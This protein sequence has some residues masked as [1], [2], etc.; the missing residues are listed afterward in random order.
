[1][2]RE[3]TLNSRA[4]G[5]G[6]SVMVVTPREAPRAVIQLSHGVCGC[7]ERFLPFMNYMAGK[8]IACV[9][10][11]HRG[12]GASVRSADDLGY[13]YEG[14]YMALVDDM[15]MI[16]EWAHETFPD[17]PLYLLGHSMGSLA[18][19]VYTKY[20]DSA[21]DGLILTGS[22]SWNPFSRVGRMMAWLLCAVGLSHHRMKMV[23]MMTSA[24]YNRRFRSEGEQAWTCSDAQVRKSFADNPVCNFVLTANGSYNLMCMMEETYEQG[25]WTVSNPSMPVVFISGS[26]DPTM[27]S[28]SKFHRAA[29]N[30]CDRGYTNVTSAIYPAMRHEVLNEIGKEELWDDILDFMG[31]KTSG[32]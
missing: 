11:D 27:V 1:M 3:M 12:H 31:L 28:E 24:G 22:P 2:I 9:A 5:L 21:I 10:G 16:T 7:K 30:L 32:R 18:A 17:V 15:R 20:D 4:D 26:E 8:G 29:Q 25:R 19:R 23:Q 14:G 6:V 13:M